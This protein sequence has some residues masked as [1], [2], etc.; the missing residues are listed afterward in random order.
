[1]DPRRVARSIRRKGRALIISAAL[2]VIV[3][4]C[5]QAPRNGLLTV[6]N[7]SR[8]DVSVH[9]ERPGLFGTQVFGEQGTEAVSSCVP[10]ARGFRPGE[11]AVTVTSATATRSFVVDGP[12][13]STAQ[14]LLRVRRDGS[15]DEVSSE[16][17]D[18]SPNCD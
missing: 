17:P 4:A 12:E 8:D 5:G 11:V 9:W 3:V 18:P 2:I 1:M 7:D 10:Y 15:M 6:E 16:S 13:G 14:Y